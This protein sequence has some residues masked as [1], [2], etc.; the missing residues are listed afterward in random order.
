MRVGII[1]SKKVGNAVKRNRVRR[2]LREL[3]RS[4]PDSVAKLQQ[5]VVVVGRKNSLLSGYNKM[6]S[7]LI[8]G[9]QRLAAK[10][11][12]LNMNSES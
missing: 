12:R 7:S 8:A 9:L 1:T 6:N 10:L 3:L 11:E 5:D 2:Q 4:L